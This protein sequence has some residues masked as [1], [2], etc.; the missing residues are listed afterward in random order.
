MNLDQ[1]AFLS[2]SPLVVYIFTSSFSCHLFVKT[3]A[4]VFTVLFSRCL[5]ERKSVIWTYVWTAIMDKISFV[6]DTACPDI[7]LKLF[8]AT[9]IYLN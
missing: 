7:G 6:A 2:L 4:F 8:K 1:A 9:S 3:F 5:L